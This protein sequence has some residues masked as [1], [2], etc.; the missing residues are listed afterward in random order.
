MVASSNPLL[1][2]RALGQFLSPAR[3]L[4]NPLPSIM[5]SMVALCVLDNTS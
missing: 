3:E 4:L 5:T 1:T 2:L